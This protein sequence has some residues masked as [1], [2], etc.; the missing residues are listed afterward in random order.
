MLATTL[1]IVLLPVCSL[2]LTAQ[3]LVTSPFPQVPLRD[4][5]DVNGDGR[6]DVLVQTGGW[7]DVMD[8]ATGLPFTFLRRSFGPGYVGIGDYNGDG[9]DDLAY[10]SNAGVFCEVVSGADGSIL[11]TSTSGPYGAVGGLDFDGD[12]RSDLMLLGPPSLLAPMRAEIRSARTGASLYQMISGAPASTGPFVIGFLP[13]GDENG[14]GRDDAVVHFNSYFTGGTQKRIVQAPGVML[15]PVCVTPLGDVT[16]DGKADFF[17]GLLTGTTTG[18]SYA[19]LAGGSLTTAWQLSMGASCSRVGDLDGDG[20]ADVAIAQGGV[21][22]ASGATLATLPGVVATQAPEPLGD[23]DGDG[24]SECNMA[25]LLYEW[26]DPALP[27]A[28]RMVRRGGSGTTIDGRK[29]TLVTRG[30]CGLGRTAFFDMRGGRPNGLTLLM[31]GSSL[32]VDLASL[33]APGNRCYTSLAGGLAFVANA[34]GIAQYQATMPV[35]PSLLGVT[36]S[37]QAIAVDPAANALGLV[38]SNAVDMTAND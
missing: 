10:S 9:K 25:G 15:A 3:A 19:V 23:L 36:L 30:H 37:L 17:E 4:I 20:F 21:T 18:P 8:A 32:D 26:S 22:I 12:G 5:G 38:T 6:S 35:T 11:H 24:R 28:S 1:R 7:Y 29:P 27:V 13:A 34:L 14:D 2:S 16:G 31:F 33:G